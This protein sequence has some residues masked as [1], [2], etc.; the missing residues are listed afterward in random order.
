MSALSRLQG[1]AAMYDAMY[2]AGHGK[3]IRLHLQDADL[4]DLHDDPANPLSGQGKAAVALLKAHI[5][6]GRPVGAGRAAWDATLATR[7]DAVWAKLAQTK[8]AGV[9][10]N[11]DDSDP[12]MVVPGTKRGQK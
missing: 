4:V 2:G 11:R 9:L 5:N 6:S 1:F 12:P 8:I 10:I 3:P 7:R